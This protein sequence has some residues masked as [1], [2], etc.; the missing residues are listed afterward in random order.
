MRRNQRRAVWLGGSILGVIVLSAA[1]SG[2]TAAAPETT[3][4]VPNDWSHHHVI[5]SRP[6]TPEQAQR[7]EKDPRYWMQRYRSEFPILLP[8]EKNRE[9]PSGSPIGADLSPR[10]GNSNEGGDWQE[11]MGSGASMGAANYPAKFSFSLSTANCG[12]AT[13]PDFVVYSSGLQGLTTQASLVAYDN[14]YSGCTGTVPS[15]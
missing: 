1:L 3:P 15:T 8:A 2:Q 12:N 4:P 13:K 7:I 5:F 10:Q 11:S 14:I 9:A 6:A